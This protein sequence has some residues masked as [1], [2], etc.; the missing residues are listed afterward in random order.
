VNEE[1]LGKRIAALD[2]KQA[3]HLVTQM[4]RDVFREWRTGSDLNGLAAWADKASAATDAPLAL[5]Q[6]A[7]LAAQF[8]GADAG[9]VARS[10]L[11]G[12]ASNPDCA[13]FIAAAIDHQ[14]AALIGHKLLPRSGLCR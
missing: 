14:A 8:Q 13:R 9:Q 3:A 6:R 12:A 4:V 10:V 7:W 11:R 1:A 2:D 5:S